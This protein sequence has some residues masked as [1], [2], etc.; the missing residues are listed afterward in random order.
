MASAGMHVHDSGGK[1]AKK[2]EQE[3]ADFLSSIDQ[4]TTS[5]TDGLVGFRSFGGG[6]SPGAHLL[7]GPTS[8]STHATAGS[9]EN[10]LPPESD[11]SIPDWLKDLRALEMKEDGSSTPAERHHNVQQQQQQ[12]QTQARKAQAQPADDKSREILGMEPEILD[13]GDDDGDKNIFSGTL[14][15]DN[16]TL[17][18]VNHVASS[19]DHVAS[20]AAA[21]AG[22]ASDG[23]V[24]SSQ[25]ELPS[26]TVVALPTE[27]PLDW[28]GTLD[29]LGMAE[30][31]DEKPPIESDSNVGVRVSGLPT[32]PPPASREETFPDFVEVTDPRYVSQFPKPD[33]AISVHAKKSGGND[34]GGDG[35]AGDDAGPSGVKS[36]A[37][38]RRRKQMLPAPLRTVEV[39]LRP[40]VTWESVSDAYMAVMLSRGLIIREQTDNMVRILSRGIL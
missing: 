16:S 30:S 2:E 33:N 26:G 21:S 18:I 25:Q 10:A 32:M 4:I 35:Y 8:P 11:E 12:Q 19:A 34:G 7:F 28:P 39:Y 17:L 24:A 1:N 20:S 9:S 22:R 5:G 40:D 13:A 23:G 36:R 14:A 37:P 3:I 6:N 31:Q 29:M 38:S 15:S 27:E